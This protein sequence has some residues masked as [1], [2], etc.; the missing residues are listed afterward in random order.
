[1]AL[2]RYSSSGGRV[3]T[4]RWI[5]EDI[6]EIE[7]PLTEGEIGGYDRRLLGTSFGEEGAWCERCGSGVGEP[8]S[9]AS[10]MVLVGRR[11]SWAAIGPNRMS[12]AG[13]SLPNR[14]PN[15]IPGCTATGVM[16]ASA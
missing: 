4:F 1:M 16:P 8:R 14:V 15:T 12:Q 9:P 3:G 10:S 13:M 2:S 6:E 7:E 11:R 5:C